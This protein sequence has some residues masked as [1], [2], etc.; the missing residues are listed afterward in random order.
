MINIVAKVKNIDTSG[1]VSKTKYDADKPELE[2]KILDTSEFVKKTDCAVKITEIKNEIPS[3]SGLATT[4]ALTVVENKISDV[5]SLVKKT[6][7]NTKF[8][9]IGFSID[10]KIFY[11]LGIW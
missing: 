9:E 5:S 11:F 3:I 7:Y 6:N 4:S 8:T 10:W 2:N 1:F